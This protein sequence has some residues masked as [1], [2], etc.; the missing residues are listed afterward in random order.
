MGTHILKTKT[1]KTSRRGE[2]G[3]GKVRLEGG[4]VRAG[5]RVAPTNQRAFKLNKILGEGRERWPGEKL[6]NLIVLQNGELH[7]TWTE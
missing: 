1:G 2:G 6:N 5:P 4:R 7:M 3:G